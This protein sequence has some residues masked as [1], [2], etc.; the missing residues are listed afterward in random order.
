MNTITPQNY[1]NRSAKIEIDYIAL[2]DNFKIIR[3]QTH[4]LIYAVVKANSYG[5]GSI[6]CVLTLNEYADGFAVATID[7][8]SSI[9]PYVNGLPILI[10]QGFSCKNELKLCIKNNFIPVVYSYKQLIILSTAKLAAKPKIFIKFNSGMGRLGF[11]A[12]D[13]DDIKLIIDG[14]F[15]YGIMSHLCCADD[16]KSTK[17]TEQI[18]NFKKICANFNSN[19]Q[20]SLANSAGIFSQQESH[21]DI[22][23]PGVSLYGISPFNVAN[24]PKLKPVMSFKAKIMAVYERN[25]NQS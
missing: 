8:A 10:F 25:K 13:I 19:I 16:K 18:K 20:K 24:Q 14:K 11:D 1:H 9:K 22:V 12:K 21:F 23:R 17:T 7:E 4:S 6:K 5:H 3:A 15:D 2:L